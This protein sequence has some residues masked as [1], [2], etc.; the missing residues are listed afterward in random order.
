MPLDY[1]V[2]PRSPS[3]PELTHATV[4]S[5]VDIAAGSFA[6]GRSDEQATSS[7]ATSFVT[8]LGVELPV[9]SRHVFV[10]ANYLFIAGDASGQA[11]PTTFVSGN[12]ELGARAVW[13]SRT[14]LSIGGA[15][16][17][18][19]PIAQTEPTS[20]AG[21]VASTA[22]AIRAWDAP[23]FAVSA[24]SLRP[25]I[26]VRAIDAGFVVQYRQ[27][28]DVIV[29]DRN[30]DVRLIAGLSMLYLGYQA[31]PWLATGLELS[32]YYVIQGNASDLGRASF[33][34]APALTITSGLVRPSV[35]VYQSFGTPLDPSVG[36]GIGLRLGLTIAADPAM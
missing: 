25:A 22:A 21:A 28:L 9:L 36:G 16:G 5:A 4:D 34:F 12:A 7:R 10:N 6:G 27:G 13:A 11:V 19:V 32:E 33:Y 17:F 30:G 14:G 26:D 18:V 2:A 3:M 29:D 1:P 8:K 24:L 35:S 20:G 31:T 23:L 15:F